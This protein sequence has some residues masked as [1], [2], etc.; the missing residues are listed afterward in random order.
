M[1]RCD[2]WAGKYGIYKTRF[3]YRKISS[4]FDVSTS[5]SVSLITLLPLGYENH[6]AF[7]ALDDKQNKMHVTYIK[8]LETHKAT[9]YNT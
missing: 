8:I 1:G 4:Y 3:I 6:C 7:V 5:N 2:L 9:K